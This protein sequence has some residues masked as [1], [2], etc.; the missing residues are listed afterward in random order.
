MNFILDFGI[1]WV[2][3]LWMCCNDNLAKGS[4]SY[5]Q[6]TGL[7]T[8]LYKKNDRLDTK[9][10]RPIS[11]LCTDYKIL[12][13][14]LTNRLKVVLHSIISESQSCGVP[15]RFSGCNVRTL[16]DIVNFC[17]FNQLGG[18]VISLD[19]EKAFDRVDWHYMMQVLERMNFGPSFR[20]W[21]RL[22]YSNIFSRV[23]V[24]GYTSN[25]FVV[26]R[27]VRQGCLLSPLLYIIVAETISSAIKKDSNI[28]GFSLFNGERVKIFQYAEDTSVIVH[29][30]HALRSL[31]SLFERYESASGAKLNITKSHGLLFGSPKGRRNHP[32][33]LNWCNDSITVLGCKLGNI[34]AVDWDSLIIKFEQQLTLW[35][36]RQL[37]FRGRALV[38]NVLGLSLFWYH[39]TI[40]DMPKT[41]VF[42]VNKI[43][44]P[45][46]WNRKREWMARTSVIQPYH[47]GG[48]GVVDIS[49][50]LLSLRSVWLRRFFSD[51]HHPWCSF[52]S[53]YIA[54][55]FNQQSV[56]QVLSRMHI[57]TYLIKKLPPFYRDILNSWVLLKGTQLNNSWFIPRLNANAVL[58][59]DLTA[60]VSYRLLTQ[61]HRTEHRSVGKFRDLD[62]PVT[63][64]QVWASL[65]LRRF[66]WSVQD[67]AWLLFHGILPTA[68][69]LVGFG[70]KVSPL[71][72]CGEPETLLH[73]FTTCPF[74]LE[75]FEWFT[76]QL[77]K[78]H[79]V[80]ALTTANILLGFESASGIPVVFTALLGILRHHV[81]LAR[82]K[83]RFEQV[84]PNALATIKQ[85]K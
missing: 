81:W 77:R 13:K 63:W 39:A 73:L 64:S 69:R 32:V 76:I 60:S 31:F 21:V 70:M 7:I 6:R 17:N 62:L 85:A 74:A 27:G 43:L 10:W 44:F 30:D 82:N 41:I 20:A 66:V 36:Q 3:I 80:S 29:S 79:Q 58:L 67:T 9:N 26:T 14:F 42:K 34:E 46:I 45:F 57:P 84:P 28:D 19:Q 71:C 1:F 25:A 75:V 48:L 72:S 83:Y 55:S 33:S 12:A 47:Q 40:F 61:R 16:Q 68:D 5:S 11:L 24:N 2:P 8:L 15:S 54:S 78:N 51:P 52:F 23:L 4:L 38:A 65:R 53:F 59:T 49:Q 35:K 50:K 56:P 18:A 37:S 22:P